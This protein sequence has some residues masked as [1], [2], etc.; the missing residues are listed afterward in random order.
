MQWL[1]CCVLGGLVPRM[2]GL[3]NEMMLTKFE[4]QI[5]LFNRLPHFKRKCG[6][7]I[8]ISLLLLSRIRYVPIHCPN[9]TYRTPCIS[10]YLMYFWNEYS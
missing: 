10:Y 7:D 6:Y 5:F 1:K 8:L 3:N 2:V 4:N 9:N